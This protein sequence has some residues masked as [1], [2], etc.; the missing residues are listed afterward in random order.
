MRVSPR[1]DECG[2]GCAQFYVHSVRGEGKQ[3]GEGGGGMT[4]DN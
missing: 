1:V 2:Y 4:R 3:V